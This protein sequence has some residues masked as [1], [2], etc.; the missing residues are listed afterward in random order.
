[1]SQRWIV[2]LSSGSSQTGVSAVLVESAG[3]G[4]E[5]RCRIVH[6][7]HQPHARELREWLL[8][9][10]AGQALNPRQV[11]LLHRYLGESF[12]GA[13][14]T[15]V[16]QA[17]F[18]MQRIL[19]TGSSGHTLWHLPE[20]RYPAVLD[21]GMSEIVAER[22]GMSVVSDFK[23][24]DLAAG[25]HGLPLTPLIDYLHFHQPNENRLLLHLGGIA[26]IVWLPKGTDTRQVIGF[27]AAPGT[28]LLDGL[29]G[30]LT[31]GREMIDAGGTH[32]VQGRCIESLV[33]RWLTHPFFQ[34]QPPRHLSAQDFG[35][36][37]IHQAARQA[38]HEGRSLHDLLCTANH[39][40]ARAILQAIKQFLPK[41]P[42][43]VLLSG[44]G[45]RNG[46]LWRLLEQGIGAVPVEK[47]DAHGVPV[48]AR[49]ALAHAGLAALA[50]DGVPANLPN[51]TGAAGPRLLGRF[52]PGSSANWARC[53]N[54]MAAQ[55]APLSLAA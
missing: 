29:M 13:A 23:T 41:P 3:T 27:P 20:A 50:M 8:R 39:F 18:P 37:F 2:G 34:K 49:N 1:M 12:A 30:L 36:E 54:W 46:L 9:A 17:R 53:L 33:E 43:R 47:T 7:L 6:H 55:S 35:G 26:T 52:T 19:C 40:V 44:G 42:D 51:V 14:R 25:G 28:L 32:A 4:M 22:T 38:T 31:G 48:D 16:E 24:R 10:S 45:V 11:V 5:W 15:V 21:L